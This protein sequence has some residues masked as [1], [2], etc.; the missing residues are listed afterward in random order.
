MMCLSCLATS[1]VTLL[2]ENECP[3]PRLT[4]IKFFSGKS[5]KIQSHSQNKVNT[6]LHELGEM[7]SYASENFE[8][9]ITDSDW[10]FEGFCD[11]ISQSFILNSQLGLSSLLS[12]DS[13]L[14]EGL[15]VFSDF[16]FSQSSEVGKSLLVSAESLEGLELDHLGEVIE[17]FKGLLDLL[18]GSGGLIELLLLEHG[19]AGG[20]FVEEI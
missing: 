2:L 3:R 13:F 14:E 19:V 7:K 17:R 4:L 15:Q 5:I 11:F 12:E 6:G 9:S 18:E 1:V 20:T 10:D 16:S 8:N